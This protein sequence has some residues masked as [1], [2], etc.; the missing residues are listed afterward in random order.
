M[1]M[2]KNTPETA[3]GIYLDQHEISS[4][5]AADRLGISRR[6][7]QRMIE[8]TAEPTLREAL[9]IEIFTDGVVTPR[10]W[11]EDER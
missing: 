5:T 1:T 9:A 4:Y 10:S 2:E 3:F 11:V 6:K 7:I 8:G